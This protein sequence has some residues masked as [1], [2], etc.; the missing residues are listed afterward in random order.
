[1]KM[2]TTWRGDNGLLNPRIRVAIWVG[3]L[4]TG[5][6]LAPVAVRAGEMCGHD[7]T[8]HSLF[9]NYLDSL[10]N[11]YDPTNHGTA[12]GQVF[13]RAQ[14]LAMRIFGAL[15]LAE[16]IWWAANLM[17]AASDASAFIKEFGKKMITVTAFSLIISNAGVSSFTT[18]GH[19]NPG[20]G[21][22][23]M[24][25]KSLASVGAD[26]TSSSLSAGSD[27]YIQVDALDPGSFIDVGLSLDMQLLT[28]LHADQGNAFQKVLAGVGNFFIALLSVPILLFVL[29]VFALLAAQLLVTLL[30]WGILCF[31]IILLGG[32][33]SRWSM[34][35]AQTYLQYCIGVGVKLLTIY[36]VGAVTIAVTRT[37]QT[38]II[39]KLL[40]GTFIASLSMGPE[41]ALMYLYLN[42]GITFFILFWLIL[43]VPGLAQTLMT[44]S[45][46]L[47]ANG[48][49]GDGIKAATTAVGAMLGAGAAGAMLTKELGSLTDIAGQIGSKFS[50]S[51]GSQFGGGNPLGKP[52]FG[53]AEMSQLSGGVPNGQDEQRA[54]FGSQTLSA[55]G[56]ES[57]GAPADETIGVIDEPGAEGENDG[58]F[59]PTEADGE[60]GGVLTQLG[61]DAALFGE[62]L[63]LGDSNVTRAVA[64][65][66]LGV[67]GGKAAA[68]RLS[69]GTVDAGRWSS[70][71]ASSKG[72]SGALAAGG[73]TA[74]AL[75]ARSQA[76]GLVSSVGLS[77]AVAQTG[78]GA[79][80]E[81][82]F[83]ARSGA[84]A[85]ASV[86]SGGGSVQLSSVG[87]SGDIPALGAFDTPPPVGSAAQLQAPV[88]STIPPLGS[89]VGLKDASSIPLGNDTTMAQMPSMVSGVG[90]NSLVGGGSYSSGARVMSSSNISSVRMGSRAQSA[91]QGLIPQLGAIGS[92][93]QSVQAS[94]TI[95]PPAPMPQSVSGDASVLG[96]ILEE[97]RG[98]RSDQMSLLAPKELSVGDRIKQT[99]EDFQR[100]MDRYAREESVGSVSIRLGGHE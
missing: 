83:V 6:I 24:I 48:L 41:A 43:K 49:L 55:K 93:Q 75:G 4:F 9:G 58:E 18:D 5:C 95:I 32:L 80:T 68:G 59:E 28:P 91:G 46:K 81:A 92:V 2:R 79:T 100:F 78:I 35:I 21:W 74:V 7:P 17:F 70:I 10:C 15:L 60:G 14:V 44:G 25:I 39:H 1:M 96:G 94:P 88:E 38:D 89:V 42:A 50:S 47:E 52:G 61:A 36:G 3:V 20:P 86:G 51:F 54:G 85:V 22:I 13:E 69:S 97:L 23:P 66:A 76:R 64:G 99:G 40:D 53:S 11:T 82:A 26:I 72:V 16:M 63:V 45:P 30:E 33:G 19:G 77:G 71:R 37:F 29:V 87:S 57:S 65:K 84:A 62:A 90:D 31:G 8:S 34:N 98:M 56:E 12:L 73:R 27:P 67:A